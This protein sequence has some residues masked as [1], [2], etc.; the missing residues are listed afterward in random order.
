MAVM[1]TEDRDRAWPAIPFAPWQETCATLHR[2]TQLAGKIR[3]ACT[4]WINHSW[5]VTLY[6]TARGLSTGPMAHGDRVFQLD[7]DFVEHRLL[8]TEASGA[9]RVIELGQTSI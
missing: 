3:L 7:F 8:L 6:V 5:H 4:P 2:M 1:N 9:R